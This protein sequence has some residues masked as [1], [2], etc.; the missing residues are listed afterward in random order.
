MVKR[1]RT[2]KCIK[3]RARTAAAP[4]LG[5]RVIDNGPQ[6]INAASVRLALANDL[7]RQREKYLA[8]INAS[9]AARGKANITLLHTKLGRKAYNKVRAK[10][11]LARRRR[12]R[13]N[14]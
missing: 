13:R 12:R 5:R 14:A 8:S 4:K 11:K 3:G 9:R 1:C 6:S 10:L 7:D 2:N